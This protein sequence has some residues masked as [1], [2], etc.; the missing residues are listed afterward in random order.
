MANEALGEVRQAIVIG[1]GHLGGQMLACLERRLME[2]HNG[3]PTVKLLA[4]DAGQG[5]E[6]RYEGRGEIRRLDLSFDLTELFEKRK[7]AISR[8]LPDE[9]AT[10]AQKEDELAQTRLWGRLAL[11]RHADQV[12]WSVRDAANIVLSVATRS[13]L[14]PRGLRV[15]DESSMDVYVIADLAEPFASGILPDLAY[16]VAHTVADEVSVRVFPQITGVLFLPSFRAP[17]DAGKVSE[18]EIRARREAEVIREAD[19]YAALKELDYY[20]DRRRYE[21]AYS[22]GLTFRHEAPPFTRS[23]Y[24]VDAINERNKGMPNLDQMTE[25]VGEWL[26]QMLASPLK[27]SFQEPGVRFAD[28]RS[29]GKVASYSS[30]G[31][32]AYFL[33]IVEVIEVNAN[34]LAFEMIDHYFLHPAPESADIPAADF[35]AQPQEVQERLQDDLAWDTKKDAF[36]NVPLQHFAHISPHDLT[37]LEGQIRRNFGYRLEQMLPRLR[38]GMDGNL[39]AMVE[40]FQENLARQVAYIINASP[41]GGVSLA[42]RFLHKLK[43]DLAVTERRARAE[44][45]AQ[46]QEMRDLGT[47]MRDD[48]ANLVA[49]V[50]TFGSRRAIVALAIS[51]LAILVWLYYAELALLDKLELIP[52]LDFGQAPTIAAIVALVGNL[53]ALGGAFGI[54]Y[55]WWRRTRYSY[56]DDHRR[57]L[58]IA[59]EIELKG[60][61]ANYY[62]QVQDV[63]DQ[64]LMEVVSFQN[65]L[66]DLRDAFA[67]D[68]EAP[69]PLYGSPRFIIEE[70]VIDQQDVDI[71]YRELAGETLEDEIL[72]LFEEYGPFYRWKD[73]SDEEITAA[74][75]AF[76]RTKFD[77]LRRT[78]CAEALLVQHAAQAVASP[79]GRLRDKISTAELGTPEN[80][81]A[82]QRRLEQLRD[83]SMPFL[84]YSD[85]ELE[86]G[87]STNL[88]HRI[89]FEGAMNED[90]LIYQVL[91]E[92]GLPRL[93]T[94]DRHR[95]IS[96]TVRHG[97]PLA[98]VGLLRRWRMQYESLR[99]RAGRQLH[100]RRS[101][102]ALPDIFPVGEDVL[103]PQ[104]AVALGVAY[105]KLRPRK[106]D[107]HYTFSY[108]DRLGETVRADLGEEKID[109]CVYLQDNPEVL[110][111]L[112]ERIDEETIKRSEQVGKDGQKRGNR[113]VIA[114]LRRYKRRKRK[115]E[116]LE[117]WEEVMI[118]EYV[119]R[120]GR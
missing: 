4:L 50:K 18:E 59:L 34:R 29:H 41:T 109:A 20:M 92:Q 35:G 40:D 100:T 47:K 46:R 74:L 42:R 80:K 91:E 64:E 118:D 45:E 105:R 82:V 24:L 110:R 111:I 88:V 65:R 117:D 27:D 10:L 15:K 21:A 73:A 70:S 89:G 57:R 106:S 22:A 26:Y 97:L 81:R 112:S 68:M 54:G 113:A 75:L 85:L 2:R 79:E 108:Q 53:F 61:E 99:S 77:V 58:R 8:W 52:L 6:D 32:A 69:R 56:I 14:G 71:F 101:H 30:L 103:Q 86:T 36:F 7:T 66:E 39:G 87:V 11:F 76:G 104:M 13:E 37:R 43:G 9:A 55:D 114:A 94:T 33:P 44:G 5:A 72:A 31:L 51:L 60:V 17:E 120:L 95:I 116:A 62:R 1:L 23:C 48:R 12:H 115:A 93:L 102:L 38:R 98:A 90:S 28:V 19:A 119:A 78:K 83:N 67:S 63:V 107:G 3:I 25:M 96:M 49:A 16:L 84:R